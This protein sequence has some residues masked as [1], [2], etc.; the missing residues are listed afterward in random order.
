MTRDMNYMDNGGAIALK[1]FNYQNAVACLIAIQNYQKEGFLLYIETKDDME[2]DLQGIHAFIQVKAQHLTLNQLL[3]PS[4][5]NKDSCI[6]SKNISKEHKNPLYQIVLLGLKTDQKDLLRHPN[7]MIFS[8]EYMYSEQQKQ[9]IIEK[10]RHFGFNKKDIVSKLQNSRLYFTPFT[11]NAEEESMYLLGCMNTNNIKI[12][13]RGKII[14]NE[15]AQIINKKA[16]QEVSNSNDITIKTITADYLKDLFETNDLYNQKKEL[17]QHL[18]EEHIIQFDE[19]LNVEKE[20]VSIPTV[21]KCS[22]KILSEH[23]KN[24]KFNTNVHNFFGTSNIEKIQ[25]ILPDESRG[26]ILA[27]LIELYFKKLRG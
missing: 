11:S 3:Q 26:S 24:I 2:L 13:N 6:L 8:N 1:G 27:L 15:L 20:L 10:I 22:L 23:F 19:K 5:I 16:E 4:K 12:D 9:K 7:S 17:I 18:L 25:K 21:H 14:L